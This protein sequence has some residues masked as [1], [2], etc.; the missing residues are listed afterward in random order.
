MLNRLTKFL[1]DNSI[2]Y[3]H[4]YGFREGHSTQLA[5][6]EISDTFYKLLDN[7]NI[8]FS[9]YLDLRKAFDC[10]DHKILLKKLEHYGIRNKELAWF[11]SYLT[12]RFQHVLIDGILSNPL[13]TVF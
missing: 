7:K 12:D 10:V 1:S 4:Q 11:S 2:L 9:L 13:K 5:L 3:N 8:I 6:L